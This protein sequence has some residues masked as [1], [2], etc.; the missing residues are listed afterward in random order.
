MG[1]RF[2]IT[3]ISVCNIFLQ[4]FNVKHIV[5]FFKYSCVH[6]H[7]PSLSS[8]LTESSITLAIP[9]AKPSNSAPPRLSFIKSSKSSSSKSSS[10]KSSSSTSSSSES[11][12]TVVLIPYKSVKVKPAFQSSSP[13]F[14]L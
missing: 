3:V 2:K 10:S 8:F 1:Y 9:A 13:I 6:F 12:S 5:E 14:Y 4:T 7:F 11:G